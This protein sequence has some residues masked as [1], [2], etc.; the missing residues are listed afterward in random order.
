M[1]PERLP[2]PSILSVL[3]IFILF[4]SR[5]SLASPSPA[6]KPQL[7]G[8]PHFPFPPVA[9][10]FGGFFGH[11]DGFGLF[12]DSSD[13]KDARENTKNGKSKAT[14]GSHK[15]SSH[16]NPRPTTRSASRTSSKPWLSVP[17]SKTIGTMTAVSIT[18]TTM[19]PKP[20]LA[21]TSPPPPPP[22]QLHSRPGFEMCS[23]PAL[24][25]TACKGSTVSEC[26]L[27]QF[28]FLFGPT[29]REPSGQPLNDRFADDG[30]V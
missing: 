15:T 11:F 4:F 16:G 18:L 20:T 27:L 30:I 7:F 12:P 21:P 6:P 14:T 24:K 2:L 10:G 17:S 29:R 8:F 5:L 9:I 22:P 3:S 1:S 19:L 26:C 23:C 25:Q 13:S 28:W